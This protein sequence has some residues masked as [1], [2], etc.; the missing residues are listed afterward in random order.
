MGGHA[1]ERHT[2]S[3]ARRWMAPRLR[4]GL[5]FVGGIRTGLERHPLVL[6]GLAFVAL[7]TVD[8]LDSFGLDDAGERAWADVLDAV[9]GPLYGWRG[10]VGQAEVAVVLIDQRTLTEFGQE[11]LP[12]A[13]EAQARILQEIAARDPKAIFWDVQY[14]KARA[15]AE[16][17]MLFKSP[18]EKV[19]DP[20]VV[21]LADTMAKIGK[22][23]PLLLGPIARN[24]EI[25]LPLVRLLGR[26]ETRTPRLQPWIDGVHETSVEVDRIDVRRYCAEGNPS[27]DFEC[28]DTADAEPLSL[29]PSAAFGLYRAYCAKGGD[30]PEPIPDLGGR[31]ISVQWGFG[32]SKWHAA[33]L[34]NADRDRCG[35]GTP[36]RGALARYWWRG[37]TRAI[38]EDEE[39]DRTIGRYCGY[40]DAIHYA[41]LD[42]GDNQGGTVG[43]HLKSKIV[44]IGFDLPSSSDR[45]S[46][47]FYGDVAGVLTHAMALDNLIQ[48]RGRPTVRPR[49]VILGLDQ[50]DLIQYASAVGI[51][52][53]IRR[54]NSRFRALFTTRDT[55]ENGSL[56]RKSCR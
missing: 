48:L 27:A 11:G 10:R 18:G 6:P 22:D 31:A 47:P 19:S 13:Y 36:G 41:D 3:R 40:A 29:L 44:L 23:R 52:C 33:L 32:V 54:T 20:G 53:L 5:R 30:C 46:V 45:R 21:A 55:S 9:A 2:W 51:F 38:R 16:R 4:A 42:A 26:P 15:G 24:N 28:K 43:A 39:D 50:L 56:A 7:V 14:L 34:S 49:Q 17:R 25:L 8:V 37:F 12:L 1:G 35:A